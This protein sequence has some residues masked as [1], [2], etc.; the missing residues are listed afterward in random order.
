MPSTP[1]A[2]AKEMI[3]WKAEN[4]W[5]SV[6]EHPGNSSTVSRT[7]KRTTMATFVKSPCDEGVI[8][9]A[10]E[11]TPCAPHVGVWVLVA[12]ILGSSRGQHIQC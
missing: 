5:A 4:T 10:P 7:R 6:L 11:A 9:S 2:L 1:L 12:T 3:Q 8:R